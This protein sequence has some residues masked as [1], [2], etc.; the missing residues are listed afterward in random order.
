MTAALHRRSLALMVVLSAGAA[1]LSAMGAEPKPADPPPPAAE[2]IESPEDAARRLK[3][4][5]ADMGKAEAGKL[6]FPAA[7]AL[8]EKIAPTRPFLTRLG[9]H[10]RGSAMVGVAAVALAAGEPEAAA[11]CYKALLDDKE[12]RIDEKGR[13]GLAAQCYFA[14]IFADKP[15]LARAMLTQMDLNTAKQ[16]GKDSDLIGRKLQPFRL[17]TMDG[18]TLRFAG[19]GERMLALN[20]WAVLPGEQHKSLLAPVRE[21]DR[22]YDGCPG[23]TLVGVN[24]NLS[25][26]RSE[27]T[28]CI[29][30]EKLRWPH[31]FEGKGPDGSAVCKSLGITG[32]LCLLVIGPDNRVLYKGGPGDAPAAWA[33]QAGL[34]QIEKK[35][36]ARP[37]VRGP[38][39]QPAST[40]V[41]P[42][43]TTRPATTPPAS[44]AQQKLGLAEAYRAAGMV[45]QARELLNQIIRDYPDS[46]QAAKAREMLKQ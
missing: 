23:F 8:F 2:K 20:T 18:R 10:D 31:V 5:A 38:T 16:L 28:Q 45:E 11:E 7:K 36:A 13:G 26:D 41:P 25:Q 34:R 21:V 14:A 17:E 35:H 42:V 37:P 24:L 43:A 1:A 9:E 39:S 15:D 19:D 33:I 44:P 40:A 3:E 22:K 4:V 32:Q 46:P 12:I 6:D 27:V 29:R 30:E